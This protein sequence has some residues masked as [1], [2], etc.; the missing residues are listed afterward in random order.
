MVPVFVNVK[1]KY[2]IGV[3]TTCCGLCYSRCTAIGSWL[4]KHRLDSANLVYGLST[5]VSNKLLCGKQHCCM[6]T[7]LGVL[8]ICAIT[9]IYIYASWNTC[10]LKCISLS[11]QIHF[12]ASILSWSY[13][14]CCQYKEEWR[15]LDLFHRVPGYF[16]C[17]SYVLR[18]GVAV[19]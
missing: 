17:L 3:T 7:T 5:C 2:I 10:H 4:T 14:K 9:F 19:N 18:V 12:K 11:M 16:P 15:L 1:L 13:G 8:W 6:R